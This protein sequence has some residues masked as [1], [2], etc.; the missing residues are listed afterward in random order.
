MKKDPVF[1]III[2]CF[3]GERY[4]KNCLN[5]INKI[6]PSE[7]EVIIINDNSNDKSREI[8]NHYQ[9]SQKIS[10]YQNKKNLGP[11]KSR[12]LGAKKAK[13]KYLVFLDIDT[14]VKNNFLAE[15][16]KAFEK[17]KKLAAIQGKLIQGKSNKIETIGHFLTFFGFPYEIGVGA[18][19]E[20]YQKERRIFGARSAGMAVRKSVF[21]EINGFDEDYFIYGE[22][23]DLCWRIWL[24]GHQIIYLPKAIIHHFSKSTLNQKT[25]FR[26]FYEGAKNNTHNILKNAPL[27]TMLWMLPL[28]ILSWL[29]ISLKLI[30]QKRFKMAFFIYRGLFW[31]IVNLPRVIKKKHQ[32]NLYRNKNESVSQIIWGK[33]SFK[34]ILTKGSKWF[35]NV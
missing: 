19:Q 5:S 35:K 2:P 9:K 7:Y 18:N 1:S 12:N 22:E 26:I 23:T 3:N 4:I 34:I 8:L 30:F 24:T 33:T 32:I 31:N 27:K 10:I 28:H 14:E 17:N 21:E 29:L 6:K 13:G 11:A 25:N 15:F 20:E 16:K